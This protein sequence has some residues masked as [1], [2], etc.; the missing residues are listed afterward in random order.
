MVAVTGYLS[1]EEKDMF[2][3]IHNNLGDIQ[4]KQL[5]TDVKTAKSRIQDQ[6][7][8]AAFHYISKNLHYCKLLEI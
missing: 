6:R 5:A 1:E 8:G 2:P 4:Q 7:L 3:L